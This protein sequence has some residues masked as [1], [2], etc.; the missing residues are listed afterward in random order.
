MNFFHRGCSEPSNKTHNFKKNHF[1]DVIT[2]ELYC[3]ITICGANVNLLAVQ[4]CAVLKLLIFVGTLKIT[5]LTSSTGRETAAP[6]Q[7]L[8]LVPGLTTP[9]VLCMVSFQC[10]S[11]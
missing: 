11:I 6:Q 2:L 3:F 8:E 5:I 4:E 9:M 10:K 1:C 7:A